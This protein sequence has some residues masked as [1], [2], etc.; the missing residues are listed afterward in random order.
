MEGRTFSSDKYRY[1]FNGKEKDD[2]VKGEEN[3]YAY[4]ERIYD[5][6]LGK[7]LSIDPLQK[8]YPDLTPY[9]FCGNN[10]IRFVDFDGNDFGVKI[11]NDNKTIVIVANVYTTSK[12]G[13]DQALK[14]ASQ[15]NSKTVNVDGY[16]VTFDIK[17]QQPVTTT[18]QEIIDMKPNGLYNKK[19]KLRE[20]KMEEFK[21]RLNRHKGSTA[22]FADPIGNL[23]EGVK[24]SNSKNVSGESYEGGVT[25]NGKKISM[26][27][28]QDE[29][30]LGN[31]P[32]LVAHEIGHLLGLDDQDGNNDK[33]NDPYYPGNGGIMEYQGLN[34]KAISDADVKTIL[35]FAKDALSGK[36]SANDAKVTVIE[37][38][39]KS[40]GSNPVGVKGKED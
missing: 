36:T 12:A 15:W 35:N 2:E 34:L 19:G 38:K 29:G 6:R 23:Y 20:N 37:N 8:K 33:K 3:S 32:D 40:D 30:D 7:W 4:D 14:A 9:N 1:G 31:Y 22:A 5:S 18:D 16:T 13:Y 10:P 27:D 11:D 28:H 24:G 21:N 17:I 26:N 25:E 39:G